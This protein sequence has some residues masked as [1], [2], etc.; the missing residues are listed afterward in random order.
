MRGGRC[1]A[2]VY[3]ASGWLDG[4][5]SE[6]RALRAREDDICRELHRSTGTA[7][8]DEEE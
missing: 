8:D 3:G 1:G 4:Y 5:A 6:L 2:S 7:N